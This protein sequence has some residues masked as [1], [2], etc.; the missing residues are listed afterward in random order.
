MTT[1]WAVHAFTHQFISRIQWCLRIHHQK[2]LRLSPVRHKNIVLTSY[3]TFRL[4]QYKVNFLLLCRMVL[5]HISELTWNKSWHYTFR[6]QIY[7][8]IPPSSG[9]FIR[10]ALSQ[11]TT[12]DT[13]R[14]RNPFP[15]S[16][17][18]KVLHRMSW[19]TYELWLVQFKPW[20][21]EI[22]LTTA[23]KTLHKSQNNSRSEV[24]LL[25]NG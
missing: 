15:Y 4:S 16:T 25:G 9:H 22:I 7:H 2:F 6:I 12:A 5:L 17:D 3:I 14:T 13:S 11:R 19:Y 20:K 8:V 21:E 24:N 1:D 10:L 23:R 18:L